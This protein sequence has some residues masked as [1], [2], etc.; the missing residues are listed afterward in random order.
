M[1]VKFLGVSL[2]LLAL[3][4][5]VPATGLTQFP[6]GGRSS[7]RGFGGPGGGMPGGGLPGAGGKGNFGQPRD[8]SGIFDYLAKGRTFFLIS[9]TNMLR[10]PLTQWAAQKGITNGQ[11]TR[12]QFTTFNQERGGYKSPGSPGGGPSKSGDSART[13][14][15]GGPLSPA[16]NTEMMGKWADFEFKRRDDNGDGMLNRDEMEGKLRDSLSQWDSNRDG[17]VSVEEYRA[18]FVGRMQERMQEK[19]KEAQKFNPVTIIIEDELEKRPIV[20][21]AGK[22]PKEVE[23][24][25]I[26]TKFPGWF[27]ELDVDKDGQVSLYEWRKGGKELEDFDTFDRNTD[28]LVTIEEVISQQRTAMAKNTQ[29]SPVDGVAT[30]ESRRPQIPGFGNNGGEGN[31][32]GMFGGNF[33]KG[34]G[35]PFGGGGFS[36]FGKGKKSK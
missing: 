26:N 29:A 25:G 20:F 31:K 4:L 3:W 1:R 33:G 6:G 19:G 22:V 13:G 12:E 5:L 30:A 10:E 35:G 8:S 7:G 24:N 14:P 15:G 17:L 23:I 18:F 34:K 21:R 32:G 2:V 28:G 27:E 16:D 11:I 36:G 9:D